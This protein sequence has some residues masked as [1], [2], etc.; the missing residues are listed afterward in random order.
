MGRQLLSGEG[1]GVCIWKGGQAASDGGDAFCIRGGL[2]FPPTHTL[3]LR[4]E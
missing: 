4:D 2:Q 1:G 3:R